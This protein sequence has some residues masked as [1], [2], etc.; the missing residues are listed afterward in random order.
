MVSKKNNLG[1]MLL[2]F[3]VILCF[4]YFLY[5]IIKKLA[6]DQNNKNNKNKKNKHNLDKNNALLSRNFIDSDEPVLSNNGYKTSISCN[7]VPPPLLDNSIRVN[8]YD[9]VENH[10]A[11]FIQ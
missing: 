2:S 9:S 11:P 6:D 8:Y 1:V 7:Y 4:I 10:G 5:V 3:V